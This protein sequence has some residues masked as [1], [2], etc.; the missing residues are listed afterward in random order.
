MP[1]VENIFENW[2]LQKMS[3]KTKIQQAELILKVAESLKNA[4]PEEKKIIKEAEDFL[5]QRD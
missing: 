2:R 3:D 1:T 5:L 4:T